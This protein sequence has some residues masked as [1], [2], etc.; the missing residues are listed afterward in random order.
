M[1]VLASIVIPGL[2]PMYAKPGRQTA[3]GVFFSVIP[4]PPPSQGQARPGDLYQHGAAC[5]PWNKLVPAKA[6]ARG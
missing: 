4:G 5:G 1:S 2:V 6:G 3:C